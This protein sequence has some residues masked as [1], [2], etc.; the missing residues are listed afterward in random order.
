MRKFQGSSTRKV[1]S[2]KTK[3]GKT[4]KGRVSNKSDNQATCVSSADL[5]RLEFHRNAVALM[6]DPKDRHPGIAI[7]VQASSGSVS[8]QFCSCRTT[9]SKTCEHLKELSRLAAVFQKK[10]NGSSLNDDFI[11]SV[12]YRL[13]S[14]M[15]EG[16]STRP[17]TVH[18]RTVRRDDGTEILEILNKQE[19]RLLSYISQGLDRSRF[20]ERCA[21]PPDKESVPTRGEVL[22]RLSLLTMT[23]DERV[24]A[25]M[26]L[27]TRRQAVE[28]N[29]WYR[30]AYHG[31]R[32]MGSRGCSFH[33]AIEKGSG[34]FV[35]TC[36]NL[37]NQLLFSMHIPRLKVKPVLKALEG[38]LLNQHGL[39]ISPIPLDAIF[40]VRLNKEMDLEIQPLLRMIQKNGEEK[41]FK[42]E[43]LEK[44]KYGD[45]YYI[46]E[47]GIL[48]EDRYPE[49]P[50][51]KFK[52]PVKTVIKKSQ[53][54][55][56]LDEFK[57][58]LVK[59][60][61]RVDSELVR[62]NIFKTFDR[63]EFIPDA[64]D[65]D[66]CWLSVKYGAGNQSI[67]LTDILK[68]RLAKQRFIATADGWIDCRASDLEPL[69]VFLDRFSEADLSQETESI[70][71]SRMDVLRLGT[72]GAGKVSFAGNPDKV[73]LF[74]KILEFK[75]TV[76][77]PR[78]KGMKS[79]LRSY[80][81]RGVEWLWFL[82]ENGLGG[83]LCDEMGLGKT[84]Q[85]MALMAGLLEHKAESGPFLVVCPT[86]VISHWHRK[87]TQHAPMLTTAVY[88]GDQRDLED[89]LSESC[90]L[91]TSY[92][93]LR[94][95]I[96]QLNRI[97]FTVAIFDEIQNLKNR[98]TLS[99]KAAN[100]IKARIKIGL[101]GTPIENTLTELK[102]LMDLTVPGYLADEEYFTRRYL[103]P[104]EQEQNAARREELGRLI[105]PFVLRRRK[106]AVLDELP[107]KIE[108]IMTCRLSEDQVKI[109]R[110]A[111]RS[112]GQDLM[113]ELMEETRPVPY[114]HIFALLNLLKQICDHPALVENQT[115]DY[116]RYE[117][118]KWDLFIEL[119]S[120]SLE[121]GQK[122]VVFSQYLG[123]IE[124][125]KQYLTEKGVGWVSLTGASRNRGRL[126]DRFQNDPDCRVYLGSL[127]AGG[128][129]IDLTAASV[130][131]HYDRWW[132]AAREDQATDRVH[133]I[134]QVRGVQVFKLVT[135]GTLE[136][137]I[138]AMIEK[139]RN[140][141][142]TVIKEDDPGLL[143][144]FTRE[145]LLE[146]LSM[147][148]ENRGI[149][150]SA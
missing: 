15:A 104:V 87:I 70:R 66:W 20:L 26:G 31:Y 133:R 4:K 147:P 1:K 18:L 91:L 111:I 63:I 123:M 145:Q 46:E 113:A 48:A 100:Q 61:F 8:Q 150:K 71:L 38:E 28:T 110:D 89:C 6:P 13:A 45:L 105:S 58:E 51:E 142:D 79:T 129:G 68:A 139:K 81:E 86:T 41:F 74:R 67:S 69:D 35:V 138:A 42:R 120:E 106:S 128:T 37:E 149:D 19:D 60:P 30:V 124:I 65:R 23:E 11:E 122:I 132:N 99:Y 16:C 64:V 116:I 75:P 88:H 59:G 73:A 29:F 21:L 39:S 9:R 56:F 57:A 49:P 140:L 135:E 24:L 102:A 82:F 84:H 7:Y 54:P 134:G 92:G 126:I 121:S 85:A 141:M 96:K 50:P 148:N 108:D 62:L 33:P 52:S 17:E 27:K 130:V 93:I 40:D 103:K 114:M 143:K 25:E 2:G 34:E 95:D 115:N 5:S 36:K 127:K 94:K 72:M 12:W 131:I 125:M 117:S 112:R 77:L 3:S 144:T 22:R 97:S 53:V 136:E 44:F 55:E 109:Y 137:K 32:E 146:L 47:L 90:L 10:L 76:T 118:G 80:Q 98:E 119:L 83:L 14:V 43:N 101:T 107:E 78:I